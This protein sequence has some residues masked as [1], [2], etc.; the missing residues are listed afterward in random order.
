MRKL[1]FT[2]TRHSLFILPTILTIASFGAESLIIKL[3]ENNIFSSSKITSF[4]IISFITF[5]FFISNYSNFQRVDILKRDGIPNSIINFVK[6]S[7]NLG[8]TII[9]CSPQYKYANFDRKELIYNRK[10]P[11]NMVDLYKPGNKLLIS[12]RP[13]ISKSSGEFNNEL[14]KYLFFGKPTFGDEIKVFSKNIKV[15]VV[16]EPYILKTQVYYDSLNKSSKTYNLFHLLNKLKN[17]Y[18]AKFDSDKI[19]SN[20]LNNLEIYDWYNFYSKATG[21][22]YRYPRPNDIWLVPIK[23]EDL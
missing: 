3:K 15:K 17:L 10:E 12:Q 20:E 9:G 8:Y 7:D 6:N 2:T 5:T 23:V 14:G 11:H 16:A 19:N 21:E 1:T 22:E 13:I 18:I 4:F